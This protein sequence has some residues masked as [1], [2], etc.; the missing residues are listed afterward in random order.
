[1][2]TLDIAA[3]EPTLTP[4]RPLTRIRVAASLAWTTLTTGRHE[5][6]LALME[7]SRLGMDIGAQ[8]TTEAFN[9]ALIRQSHLHQGIDPVRSP[10]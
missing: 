2:T 9:A 10:R 3:P 7:G 5:V 8:I 6:A 1:M 4:M